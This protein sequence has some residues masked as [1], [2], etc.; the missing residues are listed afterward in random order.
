MTTTSVHTDPEQLTLT[1]VAEFP[2]PVERL[3]AAF[4]DPRQ[5]E[6]FWGRRRSPPP[7]PRSTCAPA[8]EPT[9]G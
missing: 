5:L 3:W 8:D 7:S 4:V 9:T 1:L 2:V 6:R